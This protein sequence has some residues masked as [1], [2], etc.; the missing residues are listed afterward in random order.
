MKQLTDF[1]R[2]IP[3]GA[4]S[5]AC[6]AFTYMVAGTIGIFI[7]PMILC[8][9]CVMP[10]AAVLAVLDIVIRKKKIVPIICLLLSVAPIVATTVMLVMGAGHI[11]S[12]IIAQ[13][14]PLTK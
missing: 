4:L 3:F 5:I 6:I 11:I 1:L 7:L 8:I 9:Y 14:N 13:Y 12:D 10:V 2:K